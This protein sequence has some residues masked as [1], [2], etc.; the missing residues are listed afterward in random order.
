MLADS[1]TKPV[2]DSLWKQ[3]LADSS[4][5]GLSIITLTRA[6]GVQTMGGMPAWMANQMYLF[7]DQKLHVASLSGGARSYAGDFVPR[8]LYEFFLCFRACE[9]SPR[10]SDLL[11]NI[12]QVGPL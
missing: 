6:S 1:L 4:L 7:S 12:D 3:A 9:H 5:R 8:R 11:L 2:L 10:S